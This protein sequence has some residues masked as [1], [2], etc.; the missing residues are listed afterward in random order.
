[1]CGRFVL[2]RRAKELKVE[3]GDPAWDDEGKYLP[4]FNLTPTLST[5]VLFGGDAPHL[6]LAHWGLVPS[7]A[8]DASIG[9]RMIN[10]RA[11]TLAE[12]PSFRGLVGRRRCVVPADGYYE[13]QQTRAGKTPHYIHPPD[14]RLLLFAGLWDLWRDPAGQPLYSYTIITTAAAPALAEL[15]DRMPALLGR[16]Q[17]AAWLDAEHHPADEVRPWLRP[18]AQALVFHPVSRRVNTPAN[19]DPE[20]IAPAAPGPGEFTLSN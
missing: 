4:H 20:L 12:K 11:E 14:G 6:R 8:K 1:M 3:L 17:M 9:A 10:A 2:A 15:H 5:P 7:W 16:E 18:S 19:D 13:W